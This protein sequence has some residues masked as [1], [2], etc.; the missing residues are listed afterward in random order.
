MSPFL[1]AVFVN[2]LSLTFN[3]PSIDCFIGQHCPN[4]I[5][6]ADVITVFTVEF[7]AQNTVQ[8]DTCNCLIDYVEKVKYLGFLLRCSL[9]DDVDMHWQLHYVYGAAN[10]LHS[11]FFDKQVQPVCCTIFALKMAPVEGRNICSMFITNCLAVI[12]GLKLLVFPNYIMCLK[13]SYSQSCSC[14]TFSRICLRPKN[15]TL[16]YTPS[17]GCFFYQ[18]QWRLFLFCQWCLYISDPLYLFHSIFDGFF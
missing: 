11:K 14:D 6:Y 8:L 12:F 17:I 15:H 5:L 7:C 18:S 9:R 13:Y 2:Q 10:R 3:K 4:C 1:F 16:V